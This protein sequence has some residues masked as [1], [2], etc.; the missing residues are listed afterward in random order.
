MISCLCPTFGRVSLLEEAIESFLRQD[1]SG[2]SELIIGNDL[3]RQV[4]H[5]D[6]PSVR[7]I[8]LENRCADLGTKRNVT[9]SY[10]QGDWF[11]TW[12]DDDIH[13]PGRIRRMVDFVKSEGLNFALEGPHFILDHVGMHRKSHA[14]TGAHIIHRDHF[15]K[16]DGITTLSAG[17]D[18]NF[19]QRIQK[20]IGRLPVCKAEPQFI[21]RWHSDRPHI[22]AQK[23]DHYRLIGELTDRLLNENKEPTGDVLLHPC[24]KQDW[25]EKSKV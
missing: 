13:L 20:A 12:G 4:L 11:M 1:F 17:E 10:A 8:N 3:S 7:V 2:D 21:Y 25:I 23:H 16:V 22:S 24:W 15:Q 19:N 6:H 5:F 14:T 18:A 9:A